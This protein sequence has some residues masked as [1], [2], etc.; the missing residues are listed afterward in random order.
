MS[1]QDLINSDSGRLGLL[2]LE[3]REGKTVTT[4]QYDIIGGI[5]TQFTETNKIHKNFELN[6][7]FM[8][9]FLCQMFDYSHYIYYL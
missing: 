7:V 9:N 2:A 4:N 8:H 3:S 6:Q 5:E 1:I